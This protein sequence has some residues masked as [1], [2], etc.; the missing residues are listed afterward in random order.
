MENL[1]ALILGIIEGLTE[2]LPISSTGHMIL[3]TTILGIKMDDFWRSFLI[4]IQLGSIL[5]V[6]FV[7]W[8]KLLQSFVLW[9][10]LA[11]AFLP[12]GLIGLFVAKHLEL[13]FNGY[14]VVFML[15]LGGV[16]FIGIE[17]WHRGKSYA[18]NSLDEVS[19]KQAFFIGL[20]Q[21]LA[22]IPGTSRS[23][24]SIIGGLLLGL[25]RKVAAEFSF[26]LAVPTMMIATAYSI[27]K[28][29]SILSSASSF[30]PLFIGF[31]VAFVVAVLVIKFFLKFI[32]KFDFIP[33][34]IYRIVLGILFFYLY[35][36]GILDA[37][38]EFEL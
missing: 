9:L 17:L 31:V 16:V 12:T 20:I 30:T 33:F 35:A 7:F 8:R 23:G 21:S 3:G 2:F 38:S 37:G 1:Y 6:L 10:K 4:I 19:F 14:V 22:M 26:L 5:A 24:A 34:G 32:A 29:P 15:I 11:F 25:N 13:L 36:S 18:V 28:E 27:Y